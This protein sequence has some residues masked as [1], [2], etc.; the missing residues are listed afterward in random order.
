MPDISFV[1]V[2]TILLARAAALY[3]KGSLPLK[4]PDRREVAL[5]A[6]LLVVAATSVAAAAVA[7]AGR[8]TPAPPKNLM[9]LDPVTAHAANPVH[10]T[11]SSGGTGG[12]L[13]VRPR[14]RARSQLSF[15]TSNGVPYAVVPGK[16]Y[17][18]SVSARAASGTPRITLFLIQRT[19]GRVVGAAGPVTAVSSSRWVRARVTVT[20]APRLLTVSPV[21]AIASSPT[22]QLALPP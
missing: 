14:P 7:A 6:F 5:L 10:A 8:T 18:F 22:P 20:T 17:T 16:P 21:V 4:R 1:V 12:T 2:A 13:L 15:N 3:R 11:V 9:Q 19:G